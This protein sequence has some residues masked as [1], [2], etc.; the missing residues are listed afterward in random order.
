MTSGEIPSIGHYVFILE[1]SID[2]ESIYIC[3]M[4][5]ICKNCIALKTKHLIKLTMF[6]RLL[7]FTEGS[8][9]VRCFSRIMK[10]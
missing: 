9:L 6:G 8:T 5:F 10:T 7:T 1:T 3:N 2:Q 4:N